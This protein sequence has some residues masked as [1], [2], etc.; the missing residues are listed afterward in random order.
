MLRKSVVIPKSVI[1]TVRQVARGQRHLRSR[2]DGLG[3]SQGIRT[4]PL[5]R[6]VGDALLR[7]G[8]TVLLLLY[9][10]IAGGGVGLPHQLEGGAQ[11]LP[12]LLAARDSGVE[13]LGTLAAESRGRPYAAAAYPLVAPQGFVDVLAE[14]LVGVVPVAVAR[15]AGGRRGEGVVRALLLG[16]GGRDLLRR[17]VDGSGGGVSSYAAG[18]GRVGPRG[19]GYA[20]A[21]CEVVLATRMVAGETGRGVS[22]WL[23]MY[24][25]TPQQLSYGTI[26]MHGDYRTG[27]TERSSI[28]YHVVLAFLFS[29]S[30]LDSL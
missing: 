7:L 8:R 19:V 28:S 22:C 26:A 21:L 30:W 11:S 1:R 6:V 10:A 13:E 24:V 16:G 15:L 5:A 23:G 3:R 9:P 4:V 14:R 12:D 17:V 18:V 20:A 27:G 2:E 29:R 25:V